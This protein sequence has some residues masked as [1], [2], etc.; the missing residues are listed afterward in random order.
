MQLGLSGNEVLD[1][2]YDEAT[3]SLRVIS[4]GGDIISSNGTIFTMLTPVTVVG[5]ATENSMIGNG[6]GSNTL[7]ANSLKVGDT[8][9]MDFSHRLSSGNGQNS[10]VRIKL[11][12]VT[13]VTNNAN[14]TNGLNS[15]R[16]GGYV[17]FTVTAIGVN[18]KVKVVG[19]STVV[20]NNT[21]VLVRDLDNV[22]ETVIDTTKDNVV[23]FTYQF[24]AV[25]AS[26]SIVSHQVLIRKL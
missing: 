6:I 22:V 26:N 10:T 3:N 18:G 21:S 11:G 24:G 19:Q 15:N 20:Q 13:L 2:V 9:R 23:D 4:V 16:F 14:L 1:Y 5:I 25:N 7:L 17:D 8:I 12:S